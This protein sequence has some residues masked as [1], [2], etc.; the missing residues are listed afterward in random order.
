MAAPDPIDILKGVSGRLCHSPTDLA[1]PFPHGGTALGVVRD[2]K[3]RLLGRTR[4]IRAEE[5]GGLAVDYLGTDQGAV[6]GFILRSWD[7]DALQAVFADTA[8]GG[9]GKRVV[10]GR[11][12]T[13]GC[14]AGGKLSARARKLLFSPD[15]SHD[16]GFL[17]SKA[18]PLPEENAELRF[19]LPEEIGI[20]VLWHCIPDGSGNLYQL[21]R[22]EDLT[23]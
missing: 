19:L 4:P 2:V 16:P 20:P 18:I 5:W 6:L 1:A 9:S 21:G 13:E 15:D 11:A 8:A 23:L 12:T 7:N 22:L 14:R 3:F 10:R 17:V